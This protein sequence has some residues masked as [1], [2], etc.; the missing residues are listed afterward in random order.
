MREVISLNGMF[1]SCCPLRVP[2]APRLNQR[3]MFTTLTFY[4]YSRPGGLPDR[5]CMLGGEADYIYVTFTVAN[6]RAALDFH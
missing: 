2:T 6:T 1:T 3:P 5:Q 4:V